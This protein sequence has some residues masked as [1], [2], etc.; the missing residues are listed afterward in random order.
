MFPENGR[1]CLNLKLATT[2][3]AEPT[4]DSE[5]QA[6]PT[7]AIARLWLSENPP[8]PASSSSMSPTHSLSYISSWCCSRIPIARSRHNIFQQELTLA[9]AID[10]SLPPLARAVAADEYAQD[11]C[12]PQTRQLVVGCRCL[13]GLQVNLLR[14]GARTATTLSHFLIFSDL[15]FGGLRDCQL[16]LLRDHT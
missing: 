1:T 13:P 16:C 2:I 15:F 12:C 11:E 14:D 9:S 6:W 5:A 3:T 10:C 7:W 4:K 8:P